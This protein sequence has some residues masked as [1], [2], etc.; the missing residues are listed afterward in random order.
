MVSW[1]VCELL[2][3]AFH[4]NPPALP[5]RVATVYLFGTSQ[6]GFPHL[7]KERAVIPTSQDE[8]S[9]SRTFM[10]CL[11][12]HIERVSCVSVPGAQAG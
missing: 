6:A 7:Q 9:H 10:F 12:K 8:I 1:E 2:S 5:D 11:N 4:V 3:R